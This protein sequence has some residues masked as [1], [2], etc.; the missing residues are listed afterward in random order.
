[1]FVKADWA[2]AWIATDAGVT[3]V[4]EHA[5]RDAL[6]VNEI[7]NG[8]VGPVRKRIE[9]MQPEARVPFLMTNQRTARTLRLAQTRYPSGFAL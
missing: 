2:A 7:P 4:I 1:M 6:V 9:F 3:I 5:N 8:L